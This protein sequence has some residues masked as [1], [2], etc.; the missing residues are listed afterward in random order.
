MKIL[1]RLVAIHACHRPRF[2]RATPPKQL[3]SAG[4]A[5]QAGK[6]LLG[7]CVLRVFGKADRNRILGTACLDMCTTRTVTRFATASLVGSVR[8]R[9]GFAHC[10]SVE[11]S[12]LVLVTGDACIAP[13]I[14]A[15]GL[16]VSRLDLLCACG[17]LV[18]GLDRGIRCRRRRSR[19]ICLP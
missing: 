13:D 8:V 10:R 14:I 2:M 18:L 16:A 6:V 4:M 3:I 17:G 19:K 11:A 7:Y 15:I 9:H 1:M 5:L 12:A